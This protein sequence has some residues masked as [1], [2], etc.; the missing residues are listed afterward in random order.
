MLYASKL[1]V[2]A[3]KE[4]EQTDAP[5]DLIDL[6]PQLLLLTLQLFSEVVGLRCIEVH[7]VAFLGGSV[8][9]GWVAAF[10]WRVR[11]WCLRLFL[12]FD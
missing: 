9:L 12:L 1:I 5:A 2:A 11:G 4:V 6:G 10:G 3:L 8:G 7:H